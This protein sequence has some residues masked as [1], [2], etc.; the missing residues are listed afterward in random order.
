MLKG[1]RVMIYIWSRAGVAGRQRDSCNPSDV[2]LLRTTILFAPLW[3][4][5]SV[6]H[7]LTIGPWAPLDPGSCHRVTISHPASLSMKP[8]KH[9]KAH[10][11]QHPVNQYHRIT[12][13]GK[14]LQDYP[15]QLS[16]Y[17]KYSPL[18]CVP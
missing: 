12:M 14:S 9:W 18:H 8:V 3:R 15:V 11:S 10:D 2:A 5:G 6:C 16:T 7:A 1:K 4:L 17:Y 13:F